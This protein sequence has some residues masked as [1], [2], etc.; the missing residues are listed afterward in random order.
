MW[1]WCNVYW[2]FFVRNST[3]SLRNFERFFQDYVQLALFQRT[4]IL[5]SSP[6]LESNRHTR[7]KTGDLVYSFIVVYKSVFV[8]IDH[9]KIKEFSP[10]SPRISQVV[11]LC[12]VIWQ[13]LYTINYYF[14]AYCYTLTDSESIKLG[15]VGFASIRGCEVFALDLVRMF[16]NICL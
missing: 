5:F 7:E 8:E 12:Y 14:S 9:P 15:R 3:D 11:P 1:F 2:Y 4:W 16:Y 6:Q 10:L 13:I